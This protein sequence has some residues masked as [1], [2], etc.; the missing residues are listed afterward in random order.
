MRIDT[1]E[2]DEAT[3][4]QINQIEEGEVVV[5]PNLTVHLLARIIDKANAIIVENISLTSHAVVIAREHGIP[6]M[7]INDSELLG[8][9][10]D[11]AKV[12][13]DG[14]SGDILAIDW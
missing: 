9:L 4:S 13:V 10:P 3:L 11:G 5:N 6:V 14:D 2:Y 1:F 12:R 7:A 8:L